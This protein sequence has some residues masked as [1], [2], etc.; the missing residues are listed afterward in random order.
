MLWWAVLLKIWNSFETHLKLSSNIY[1]SI[2]SSPDTN[3]DRLREAFSEFGSVTDVFLPTDRETSRPRG[4]GFVTLA[5]RTS[6][7]AAISKMD[8]QQLDGRTIRVNEGRPKGQA[9]VDRGAGPGGKVS[10]NKEGLTEVKLYVGN[11]SFDTGEESVKK[12]FEVYGEVT[13]CFLPI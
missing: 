13:D 7:E 9:P 11:L 1:P 3:E 10:F 6:A 5:N 4:F 2:H 12:F 8:Q